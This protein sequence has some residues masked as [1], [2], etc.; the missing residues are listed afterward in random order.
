M[1]SIT[2]L[3]LAVLVGF[4]CANVG[5]KQGEE[6]EFKYVA[7]AYSGIPDLK[8]QFAGVILDGHVKFQRQ[9]HNIVLMKIQELRAHQVNGPMP[10]SPTEQTLQEL[11]RQH[12]Q[13]QLET[14]DLTEFVNRPVRI[15]YENGRIRQFEL[16]EECEEWAVNIMKG[17]ISMIKLKVDKLEEEY[18]ASPAKINRL[19]TPD[20][21]A[22]FVNF[23]TMEQG[24]S[25]TCKTT[26]SV[27]SQPSPQNPTAD[28]LNI[29]KIRNYKECTDRPRFIRQT[30][31][32]TDCMNCDAENPDVL[33]NLATIQYN[34]KGKRNSFEFERIESQGQMLFT[35]YTANGDEFLTNHSRVL[36]LKQKQAIAS[37]IAQPHQPKTHTSLQ[38][39]QPS[40][41]L[42]KGN[43]YDLRK[44]PPTPFYQGKSNHITVE[45]VTQQVR[46]IAHELEN[47]E[48]EQSPMVLANAITL[49]RHIRRLNYQQIEQVYEQVAQQ[50]KTAKRVAVDA[51]VMAGTNPAIMV[52][53]KLIEA[54]QLQGEEAA[55]AL[56]QIP[57]TVQTP[58]YTLLEE[59]RKIC[60]SSPAQRNSQIYTTCWLSFG[61]LVGIAANG[62]GN[63]RPTPYYVPENAYAPV[64]VEQRFLNE[65]AQELHR[66]NH[67]WQKLVMIEALANTLD[68]EVID[69]VKPFISG[70]KTN[71][72]ILRSKAIYALTG[73]A[74]ITP[75][76][77]MR[78][79]SPIFF[80]TQEQT[81]VRTAALSVILRSHPKQHFLSK[82]AASTWTEPSQQVGSFVY[83]T[84]KNL[85]QADHKCLKDLR[86][87]AVQALE[88]ANQDF[89]GNYLDSQNLYFDDAKMAE[90][91]M[92]STIQAKWIASNESIIPT[93]IFVGQ[94]K[95]VAGL[96][97]QPFQFAANIKGADE[98]LNRVFGPK[99]AFFPINSARDLFRSEEREQ[100]KGFRQL[101]QALN[102]N[103]NERE[104][105]DFLVNVWFKLMDSQTRNFHINKEAIKNL[106]NGNNAAGKALNEL[107]F[108][109][110]LNI[111]YNK[112]FL[113]AERQLQYPTPLGVSI[114]IH[115]QT[116][117]LVGAKG[118]L[119][120]ELEQARTPNSQIPT[121]AR[122]SANIRPTLI[123]KSLKTMGVMLPFDKTYAA[124]GVN[125]KVIISPSIKGHVKI[126]LAEGKVSLEAQPRHQS[127]GKSALPLFKFQVKPFTA[128]HKYKENK[129]IT[130]QSS[131][132]HIKTQ[133][134]LYRSEKQYLN[135]ALGIP[136]VLE[137]KTEQ[138]FT[139][140]SNLID[141]V[142]ERGVQNFASFWYTPQSFKYREYTVYVR[143]G[144]TKEVKAQ[145]SWDYTPSKIQFALK[146]SEYTPNNLWSYLAGWSD[147]PMPCKTTEELEGRQSSQEAQSSENTSSEEQNASY[148]NFSSGEQKQKQHQKHQQRQR[149]YWSNWRN[150]QQQN[151][152]EN[153][154]SE[155]Q[156][157][158]SG[159]SRRSRSS[160]PMR[161]Q[162]NNG[163]DYSDYDSSAERQSQSPRA[164]NLKIQRLSFADNVPAWRIVAKAQTVGSSERSVEATFSGKSNLAELKSSIKFQVK[165]QNPKAQNEKIEIC[166]EGD[167]DY[168]NLPCSY[169]KFQPK[170]IGSVKYNLKVNWGKHQCQPENHINVQAK[171]RKSAKQLKY[172]SEAK[173][174]YYTQCMKER[175]KGKRF[176]EACQKLYNK[177]TQ[178]NKIQVNIKYQNVPAAV[179]NL[180]N[181]IDQALK[182]A[183][184]THMSNDAVSSNNP[185]H[186]VSIEAEFRAARASV[187]L[188]IKKPTETTIF[189]QYKYV[190]D[191]PLLEAPSAKRSFAQI[192]AD[193][194]TGRQYPPSCDISGGKYVDT[195]NNVTYKAKMGEC[196]YL[197]ARDCSPNGL[198]AVLVSGPKAP[199]SGP[200]KAIKVE[201][202]LLQNK[203]KMHPV[204]GQMNKYNIEIN[205]EQMQLTQGEVIVVKDHQET[206]GAGP[207]QPLAFITLAG[208]FATVKAPA[209]GLEIKCDG[210]DVRVEA[211]YFWKGKLCGLCGN[212]DGDS[213]YEFEGP[214][215]CTFD[216][217]KDFAQS[218]IVPNGQCQP[219]PHNNRKICRQNNDE[220]KS[221]YPQLKSRSSSRQAF[222]SGEY[223]SAESSSSQ[224]YSSQERSSKRCTSYRNK[225]IY[226]KPNGYHAGSRS[227]SNERVTYGSNERDTQRS[228]EEQV[229]RYEWNQ[230]QVCFS[231]RPVAHCKPGCEPAQREMRSVRY[232]C[233]SAN[234]YTAKELLRRQ[235][236]H[237]LR[238]LE[239]K[240]ADAVIEEQVTVS[241]HRQN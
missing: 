158:Q 126:D 46:K 201:I 188:K 159:E 127:E 204:N 199:S 191:L 165:I 219:K 39:Q 209:L 207:K 22:A 210:K 28:V 55:L 15:Q 112:I 98:I 222:A 73:A 208:K 92:Y 14:T 233:L 100:N 171:L 120:V 32:N 179:R 51:M 133:D 3:S 104:T 6:Y 36:I 93:K 147:I 184:Y 119:N 223:N 220:L 215:G 60:K 122:L 186:Q 72:P 25:G 56:Q 111:N 203:I 221:I 21:Q 157:N 94:N 200:G 34:L 176:E 18:G 44:A 9:Q 97:Y 40:H 82:L 63:T 1:Q 130:D 19:S 81:E 26:Y 38:Y 152:Q 85:A 11:K 138:F 7:T 103:Q 58:H 105:S 237:P 143:H 225:V 137:S 128:L 175:S 124:A 65:M 118:H 214:A 229:D 35:P 154:S 42:H 150:Q 180:T 151:S 228:S 41:Q 161:Y 197:A 239:G 12:G 192:V 99:S 74:R 2:L 116:P 213:Q 183:L 115:S 224:E 52:V 218:Y 75:N 8:N 64:E 78:A 106:I 123:L 20:S 84:L 146:D 29:T 33:H 80:N 71:C 87:Q 101:A 193:K 17:V 166:G 117:V 102:I 77:V 196:T 88:L 89:D 231:T 24:V 141:H 132:K 139:A 66:V 181:K 70:Q 230:N 216:S 145:V 170:H 205:G 108:G 57:T 178:L 190:K 182:T 156:N 47:L 129:P 67:H 54:E 227:R 169:E 135:K 168:P 189:N 16:N 217:A 90:Y 45:Q 13:Q 148:E 68:P 31:Q 164:G 43:Q 49:K 194:L 162:K 232:H 235:P 10:T 48:N 113:S 212:F 202:R 160:R 4:A 5:F 107:V 163:Q 174:W 144:E 114:L 79:L 96:N 53:K 140:P 23:Q 198:F 195:F 142:L 121:S 240:R 226:G 136:V 83:S 61:T 95:T 86:T 167:A 238:E 173:P 211:S 76:K 131:C 234:D 109:P 187:C 125:R 236:N 177:V 27:S 37:P 153:S 59:F 30:L 155:E 185:N 91:Q 149:N 69:I 50:S 172:E 134:K 206:Q 241:C 110:G 62:T